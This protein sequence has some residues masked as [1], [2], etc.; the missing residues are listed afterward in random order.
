MILK[1]KIDVMTPIHPLWK[2]FHSLLEGKRGCNFRKNKKGKIVWNCEGTYERKKTRKILKLIKGINIE[3]S[4]KYFDEH[5]GYCDCEVLWNV[6]PQ[7]GKRP[8][9][10]IRKQY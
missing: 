10:K 8:K 3:K 9:V 2:M 7:R 1:Y 5:G 6:D 4:L